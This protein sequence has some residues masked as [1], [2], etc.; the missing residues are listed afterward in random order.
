MGTNP[1]TIPPVLQ[2]LSTLEAALLGLLELLQSSEL[3]DEA[4]RSSRMEEAAAAAGATEPAGKGGPAGGAGAGA[5]PLNENGLDSE[6][7]AS[8]RFCAEYVAGQARIL[9]QALVEVRRLAGG[10]KWCGG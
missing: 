1:S 10:S 6:W 9:E 8:R 4:K 5:Q 3:L 7:Q 2:A